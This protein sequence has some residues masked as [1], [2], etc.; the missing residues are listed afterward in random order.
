MRLFIRLIGICVIAY[1]A[2]LATMYVAQRRLIYSNYDNGALAA[3][4]WMAIQNSQRIKLTTSD[5]EQLSAWY[6]APQPGQPIFLFFHGKGSGLWRKKWRWQRIRKSGAGIFVFSYRGYPG[7]TGHPTE[8]GLNRD[9]Q[10]AYDWLSKRHPANQIILHGLSLGT[11]VATTLATKVKARAL[12]LEA[13]YTAIVDVAAARYPFLPVR[14]L[15]WDKF[16]SRD[17]IAKV[18]MPVLILHGTRDSIIPFE[19]AKRLYRRAI[20]PKHLVAMSG[21]DHNTLVRDGLY[22]HVWAFLAKHPG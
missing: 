15:L 21:S 9:A 1:L 2:I 12:V 14:L 4:N 3:A 13:P 5:N 6:V 22:Q 20:Q 10:A 16:L 7:S 19:H 18:S 17:R 11:G 8:D